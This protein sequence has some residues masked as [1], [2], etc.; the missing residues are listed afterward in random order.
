MSSRT[1]CGRRAA[2]AR[3]RSCG[4]APLLSRAHSATRSPGP[5]CCSPSTCRSAWE[6]S[7]RAC[8]GCRPSA[9]GPTISEARS[10]G[11][12]SWSPMRRA[13]PRYRSPSSWSGSSS[14][15]GSASTS[16]P[17]SSAVM[18]GSRRT[19]DRYLASRWGWWG[20]ERSAPRWPSG[21]ERW[22]CGCSPCG[23]DPGRTTARRWSTKWSDRNAFT[24]C[25]HASML[26][27]C[28]PRPPPRPKTSSTRPPS[29]PSDRARC[30][31]TSREA[32]SSTRPR[33]STRSDPATSGRQCSTSPERS[34][35]PPPAR[36]GTRRIF[37]CRRTRRPR[38][39]ITSSPCSTSSPTTSAAM[40]VASRSATWL[41]IVLASLTSKSSRSATPKREG[42]LQRSACEL[43]DRHHA[44]LLREHLDADGASEALGAQ[45]RR[46]PV[47][48]EFT[49]AGECAPVQRVVTR[50]FAGRQPVAELDERDLVDRE[51][52][53]VGPAV[54]AAEE[55]PRVD[56]HAR[57]DVT[58]GAGEQVARVRDG[59]DLRE[60]RELHCQADARRTEM[61]GAPCEQ[62]PDPFV[63]VV[64]DADLYP[65]RVQGPRH[66]EQLVGLAFGPSLV[67]ADRQ[68][69]Q[70]EAR[71]PSIGQCVGELRERSTAGEMGA[72]RED[73][74][75]HHPIPAV[76]GGCDLG[77]QVGVRFDER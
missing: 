56:D 12:T 59:L 48:V 69:G 67:G 50:V 73:V 14:P 21:H 38:S 44:Q 36:C 40:C 74:G 39:T 22:E 53:E 34:R 19:A 10:W 51:L 9:P 47:E 15:S 25:S 57:P 71:E 63:D 62:A 1:V 76:G 20:W 58:S 24:T 29:P 4:P 8:A 64:D 45:T 33:S 3:S 16:L 32:R 52:L 43:V 46:K 13:L 30:S 60:R 37:A 70:V 42:R 35:W 66:L 49:G 6:R 11:R 68:P 72:D 26:S 41:P 17:I 75:A 65:H 55:V 18:C 77:E 5:R 7:R 31:A 54:V 27:S 23:G 28:V 61:V 2:R